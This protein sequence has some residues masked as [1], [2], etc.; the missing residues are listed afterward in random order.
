MG[1]KK[2]TEP[3]L[4]GTWKSDRSRTFLHFRPRRGCSPAS[5]RKLKELFGKLN[6]QWTRRRCRTNI[7]GSIWS[8]SYKVLARDETSVVIEFNEP[9]FPGHR[10]HQIHFDENHYYIVL[11]N[12]TEWFRK[13]E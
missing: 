5:L 9:M 2:L 6:V 4:V 3:R 12:I 11:G 13:V 1:D 8:S 7:D 10:L